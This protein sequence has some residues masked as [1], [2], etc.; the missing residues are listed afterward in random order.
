MS[1]PASQSV[2][3]P[4]GF[5]PNTTLVRGQGSP[6]VFLHGPFGQEWS[7]FLNDVAAQHTVFA[8]AH[9][10]AVEPK[11]LHQLDNLWDLMLYYDDVLA[12]LG[13][14]QVDLIGHSFGGMV[15]AELAASFPHRVGKLVLIDALGLW[16]DDA[17]VS[18]HVMVAPETQVELLYRNPN[19]PEVAARLSLPEDPDEKVD[20]L[21]HRVSSLASTSHFIWPIPERGLAKRLRRVRA[22]TLIVWGKQDRLVPVVYADEF[23]SRIADAQVRLIDNAGHV[24]YVEQHT[25]V[26]RL[27]REFLATG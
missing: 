25:Q 19:T 16:R 5:A 23:A 26:S 7:G 4:G 22:K 3:L 18:D 12:A 27:V 24:P 6:V 2:S 15:A 13:L 21:V 8:P 20:A 17:P 14:D 10:G 9:P 1:A 11:D